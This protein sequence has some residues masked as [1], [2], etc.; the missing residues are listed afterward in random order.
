MFVEVLSSPSKGRKERARGRPALDLPLA[1][2]TVSMARAQA[3]YK[4][5]QSL[6]R[7]I[8]V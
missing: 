2:S 5:E 6:G 1:R 7:T 8:I 4:P 3:C